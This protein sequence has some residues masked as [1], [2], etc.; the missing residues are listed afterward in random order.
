LFN[1]LGDRPVDDAG[2]GA[3]EL[4]RAAGGLPS[5]GRAL[6]QRAVRAESPGAPRSADGL[7]HRLL[8][9]RDRGRDALRTVPETLPRLL[10]AANDGEQ[11]QTRHAGWKPSR[12]LDR[13]DLLGR[14]WDQRTALV[15]PVDPPGHAPHPL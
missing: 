15:L 9:R 2:R 5:D 13:S 12:L 7:V 11:R 4:P 8:R 10:A 6:P 3:G 1:G 14:A